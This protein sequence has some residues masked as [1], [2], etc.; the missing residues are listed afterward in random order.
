MYL[1]VNYEWSTAMIWWFVAYKN[2]ESIFF[3]PGSH[4]ENKVARHLLSP[5]E[6]QMK[7]EFASPSMAHPLTPDACWRF[8]LTGQLSQSRVYSFYVY[9]SN[10]LLTWRTLCV[11]MADDY[12]RHDFELERRIFEIDNKCS[13]LRAEKQGIDYPQRSIILFCFVTVLNI[14]FSEEKYFFSWVV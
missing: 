13:C 10:H 14:F 5:F 4:S 7:C 6:R 12:R 2:L 11:V 9:L 8:V 3:C 1:Y